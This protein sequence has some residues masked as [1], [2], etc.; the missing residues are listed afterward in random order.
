LCIAVIHKTREDDVM[1]DKA[2]GN[3]LVVI[4]FV[5]LAIIFVIPSSN[6]WRLPDWASTVA[7][8][9]F[10]VALLVTVLAILGLGQSIT[11][12][13]VPK[14]NAD[15]KTRGLYAAV[16]HPIY[17]GILL[18]TWSFSVQIGSL[19][20]VAATVGLTILFAIKARF[21]ERMLLATYPDYAAYAARVGRFVPGIGK[22][23]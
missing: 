7:N 18:A 21:E 3:L 4:Q 5:L 20:S 2:R 16:R 6:T 23:K 19:W 9:L 13:P 12:N 22:L 14:D 15:L 8:G 10:M 17:S 1:T 11:A